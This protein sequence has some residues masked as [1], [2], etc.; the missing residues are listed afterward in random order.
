MK[1]GDVVVYPVWFAPRR[2]IRARIERVHRNGEVSIRAVCEID[3]D[4]KD[5]GGYIGYRYRVAQS[6]L[7]PTGKLIA[8]R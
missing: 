8:E 6:L 5:R 4:G 1:K 2:V 3:Q 7:Q